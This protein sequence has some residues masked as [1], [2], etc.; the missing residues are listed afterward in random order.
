[1][2]IVLKFFEGEA[3]VRRAQERPFF[4]C[5]PPFAGDHRL[6]APCRC[7]ALQ[8]A[9]V[10]CKPQPQGIAGPAAVCLQP[11]APTAA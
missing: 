6:A 5:S 8:G 4:L 7:D 11:P 9:A 3:V 2:E 10:L 1:M